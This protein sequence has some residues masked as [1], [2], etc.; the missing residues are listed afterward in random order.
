MGGRE[1]REKEKKKKRE[2]KIRKWKRRDNVRVNEKKKN[3]GGCYRE[4]SEKGRR[5]IGVF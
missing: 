3:R 2:I 4:G 1:K 5:K